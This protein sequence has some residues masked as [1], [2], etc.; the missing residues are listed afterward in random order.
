MI[1]DSSALIL[2]G[3]ESRRMGRDKASLMLE[4]RSMLETVAATMQALFAD[5]KLG[6]R[7]KRSDS[8]LPQILDDPGCEGPL[9]G[10]LSGLENTSA[11][12]LFMVG[13]DMPFVSTSVI[14]QLANRRGRYQA[15]VP[16]V[17]GFPQP[18]AAFYALNGLGAIRGH[19][20]TGGT[21]SMRA[22]L[23][24][25]DVCFVR[26]SELLEADPTLRSFVDLDTPAEYAREL[27]RPQLTQRETGL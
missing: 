18:L 5:V 11:P 13:C 22:M 9:A 21:R 4:G 3:G 27:T 2:A 8:M 1:D 24:K 17:R 20:A 14:M 10:L 25:L 7:E 26:E 12:W 23:E 16:V 19:L 15:V 6:V